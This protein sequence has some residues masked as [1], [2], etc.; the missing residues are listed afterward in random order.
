MSDSLWLRVAERLDEHSYMSG[1]ERTVDRV[2]ATGEV[3]TP[4]ALVVEMLQ[5]VDLDVFAP[6][7]TV[8]DPA[9][10][11]GQFLVA[12]KWV[13]V[14]HHGMEEPDALA[15]LFGVDIM[16]DNVDLCRRRL[17]GGTILMGDTLHPDRHLDG[18]TPYEWTVMQSLFDEAASTTRKR[19]PREGEVA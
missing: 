8:L 3:F 5:Y 4:T 6:G 13:K 2:K 12:A 16:R 9:C 11:D 1:A 18:Q 15:D 17:G 14:L 7:Q 10:G 19:R